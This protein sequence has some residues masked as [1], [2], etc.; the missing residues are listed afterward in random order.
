MADGHSD[1][2]NDDNND[3]MIMM[4]MVTSLKLS[5]TFVLHYGCKT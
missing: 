3:T 5:L 4:M 1:D 2:D